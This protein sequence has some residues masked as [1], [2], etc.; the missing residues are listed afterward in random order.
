MN[1]IH[2]N[3]ITWK[4]VKILKDDWR[5][6]DSPYA[7]EFVLP[8]PLASWDV[9]DYW[10]KP[11][12]ESMRDNL[13]RGDV[14]FDIGTEQGWCNLIYADFVGPENM[15]LIE[16]TK[17]FWGNIKHTWLKNYSVN[18][19]ATLCALLSNKTQNNYKP[20]NEIWCSESNVDFIIDRN[21][22][23]YIH[24]NTESIPEVKLDDYVN[25]TKIIPN[26]LTMDVE[27]AEYLI[28]TGAKETIKK[29]KPKIWI[30]IHPDMS[31]RDYNTTKEQLI[32]LLTELGYIGK[33]LS[34]DHEEHWYFYYEND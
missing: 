34:T 25:A 14:L 16:P 6:A 24:E 28:L 1:N 20:K 33:H 10:E 3:D 27:G 26:A 15:V 19:R 4:N 8:E 23:Q 32:D 9:Y 29:Y 18:P 31:I 12:F 2:I 17:E 21:K 5:I 30:S 13:N 11:R 22:Y 7:Y